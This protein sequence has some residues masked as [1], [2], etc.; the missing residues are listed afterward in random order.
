MKASVVRLVFVILALTPGLAV[1]QSGCVGMLTTVSSLCTCTGL[2]YPTYACKGTLGHCQVTF[3]ENVCGYDGG[4]S[5]F[6]TS[7]TGACLPG[8]I[9]REQ[10]E[11]MESS[12]PT[13]G[14]EPLFSPHKQYDIDLWDKLEIASIFRKDGSSSFTF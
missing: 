13:C 3:N 1:A 11:A 2:K 9:A 7:A 14:G 8:G 6:V 12:I 4:G 5:C 10:G